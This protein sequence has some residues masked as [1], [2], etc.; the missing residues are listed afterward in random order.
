MKKL[1]HPPK[2]LDGFFVRIIQSCVTALARQSGV[3]LSQLR[4][5]IIL[6]FIASVVSV[7]DTTAFS[8]LHM[9]AIVFTI[10]MISS[11]V[12]LSQ[13]KDGCLEHHVTPELFDLSI[14]HGI[15]LFL[16][17]ALVIMTPLYMSGP[18]PSGT[19][20]A[21]LSFTLHMY[22]LS[23]KSDQNE[24]QDDQPSAT[25]KREFPGIRPVM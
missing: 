3:T 7:M 17:F 8:N 9:T 12:F 10:F 5:F 4:Y 24:E 25:D 14:L 15:R 23:C 11:T 20:F 21:V 1:N 22:L 2:G 13:T 19:F 18:T 6:G 16:V